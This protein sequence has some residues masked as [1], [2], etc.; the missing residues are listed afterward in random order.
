VPPQRRDDDLRQL[1]QAVDVALAALL[2]QLQLVVV[3]DHHPRAVGAVHHVLGL[4]HRHLMRRVEYEPNATVATLADQPL[5]GAR[6]V[7][8]DD[9]R[10]DIR[11]TVIEAEHRRFPHRPAVVPGEL[12]VVHVGGG[13]SR[14]AHLTVEQ[15]QSTTVDTSRRE[16]VP[17]LGRVVARSGQD[18]RW[19][20]QEREVVGV[21]AG[22]S[23]LA[24]LQVVD[25]E[26]QVEDVRLVEKDVVFESPLEGEDVVVRDRTG[27]QDHDCDEG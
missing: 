12:V 13:E 1:Q 8:S 19:I 7:R 25:Q 24:L 11:R 21:V 22:D 17:I 20:T 3:A 26:A 27:T 14:R 10:L 18:P 2:D 4:H 15:A 16:P 9:H 5:H 23:S 6:V